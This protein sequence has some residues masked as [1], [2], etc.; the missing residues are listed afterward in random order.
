[1]FERLSLGHWSSS[2]L[3]FCTVKAMAARELSLRRRHRR[4]FGRRVHLAMGVALLGI[5]CSSLLFAVDVAKS[6]TAS[7]APGDRVLSREPRGRGRVRRRRSPEGP[8]VSVK[9]QGRLRDLEQLAPNSLEAKMAAEDVLKQ[10][11]LLTRVKESQSFIAAFGR[12]QLWQEALGLLEAKRTGTRSRGDVVLTN[13]AMVACSQAGEWETV[14]A[15]LSG[16]LA[17]DMVSYNLAMSASCNARGWQR[18]LLLLDDMNA[19]KRRWDFST[20]NTTIT[21]CAQGRQW[22][23]GVSTLSNMLQVDLQPTWVLYNLGIILAGEGSLWRTAMEYLE[24]MWA[25]VVMPDSLTYS[26][27]ISACEK[28]GQ[29]QEAVQLVHRMRKKGLPVKEQT[30]LSAVRACQKAGKEAFAEET[31][32]ELALDM[33]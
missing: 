17:P 11:E 14:L 29:W 15:L 6:A 30:L 19:A 20:Y 5:R 1:M 16:A 8:A 10:P 4:A 18:V 12:L 2:R 26:S 24:D 33:Q 9:N 32:P 31:F 27:V 28:A 21:A 13:A 22:E 25:R 3:Y 7:E 23:R